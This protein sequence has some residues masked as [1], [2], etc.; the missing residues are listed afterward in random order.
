MEVMADHKSEFGLDFADNKKALDRISIIRSKGL[1]NEIAG[2]ITKYVKH[3]IRD[4]EIKNAE[5]TP[6]V[7]SDGEAVAA[8]AVDG[9]TVPAPDAA[10][11]TDAPDAAA[12]TDASDAPDTDTEEGSFAV[13]DKPGEALDQE[14]ASDVR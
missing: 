14:P 1:K 13:M 2:Y 4:E 5:S 7:K 12:A 3:E 8:D 10:A 6:D 11:A 9:G